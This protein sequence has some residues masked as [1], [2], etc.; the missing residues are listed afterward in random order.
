MLLRSRH[1]ILL[2][3]CLMTQAI[4]SRAATDELK[5]ASDL[6]AGADAMSDTSQAPQTSSMR[7]IFEYDGDDV[8]LVLQ[9]PLD[10]PVT[11]FDMARTQREGFFVDTR[12]ASGRTLARVPARG[13][14]HGSV[15]VFPEK[16]GDPITRKDVERPKGAFT[17]IVPVTSD[18]DHVSVVH[19]TPAQP[20]ATLPGA[21]TTSQLLGAA[22]EREV[23]RFPLRR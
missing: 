18:A 11:G 12:E 4:P 3:I 15:E 9:Q 14:F 22:Q 1:L 17:V 7:L 8:R 5:H 2:A 10:V 19:V 21:R 6:N 16:H 13:A 23:A 20:G